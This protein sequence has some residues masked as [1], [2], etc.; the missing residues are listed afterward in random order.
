MPLVLTSLLQYVQH[1]LPKLAKDCRALFLSLTADNWVYCHDKMTG[2][3]HQEIY[4]GSPSRY[5]FKHI[6]WETHGETIILQ[7]LHNHSHPQLTQPVS[8]ASSLV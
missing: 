2:K 7:S 5:K 3:V 4:L 6:D 8:W 1:R